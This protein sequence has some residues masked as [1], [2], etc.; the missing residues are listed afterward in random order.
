MVCDKG[1][2]FVQKKKHRAKATGS[3]EDQKCILKACHIL[4]FWSNQDVEKDC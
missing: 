4:P 1:E 3:P 2:V